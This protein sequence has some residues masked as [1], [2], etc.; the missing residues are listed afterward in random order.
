METAHSNTLILFIPCLCDFRPTSLVR[1]ESCDNI[2]L[3]CVRASITAQN[4]RTVLVW[5]RVIAFVAKEPKDCHVAPPA[6]RWIQRSRNFQ[7]G[8]HRAPPN[9]PSLDVLRKYISTLARGGSG[10]GDHFKKCAIGVERKN[11]STPAN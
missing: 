9:L 3:R 2:D 4:S 1:D 6:R 8:D 11:G 5:I 10:A 7:N